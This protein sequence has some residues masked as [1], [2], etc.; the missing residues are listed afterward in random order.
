MDL[1]LALNLLS[2]MELEPKLLDLL[3]RKLLL[4]PMTTMT[5]AREQTRQWRHTPPM[6]LKMNYCQQQLT[7]MVMNVAS[8][9]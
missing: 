5:T 6:W 3:E 2:L 8:W 4:L 7:M 9:W 1:L